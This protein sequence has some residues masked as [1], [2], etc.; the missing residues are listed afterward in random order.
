MMKQN[1]TE[2]IISIVLCLLPIVFGLLIWNKL[3]E[4]IPVHFNMGGT[5]DGY[6]SKAFAIFGL[7]CILAVLDAFCLFALGNDPKSAGHSKVLSRI[8][9]WFIPAL[10]CIL[11]PMCLMLALGR[12]I[13]ISLFMNLLIGIIFVIIGN[14]LPKCR[15]NYTMGIRLPWTL[16][17]ENNW[18]YTHRLGGFI[19]V[20][21]GFAVI[22]NSFF[23]SPWIL[24]TVIIA[25]VLIPVAAS[26]VYYRRHRS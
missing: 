20:I 25:A 5:A 24:F 19:W 21:A 15:Q 1:K 26:Y 11:V 12:K 13:N 9:L 3:P 4:E 17:D 16:N 8:M 6:S 7:P 18:N 23:G 2:K 10:S 14:Y 22:L